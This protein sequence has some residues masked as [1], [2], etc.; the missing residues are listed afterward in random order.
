MNFGDNILLWTLIPLMILFVSASYFR[1]IISDD[2][3]V[4]YEAPCDAESQSCFVGCE[5]EEC[6]LTYNYSLIERAAADL[7]KMCGKSVVDCSF[8]NSCV[9]DQSNSCKIT[10]CDR[11]TSDECSKPS[12][13][14]ESANN[15]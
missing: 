9:L 3:L 8:A 7:S 2:Y 4:N 12:P 10:Y 1:F 6:S 15:I 5:D 11:T 14:S 13:S